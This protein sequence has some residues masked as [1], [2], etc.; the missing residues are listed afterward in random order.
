MD[1]SSSRSKPSIKRR[2]LE[3]EGQPSSQTLDAPQVPEDYDLNVMS[4]V[5][6][7]RE[8]PSN[9]QTPDLALDS[10]AILLAKQAFTSAFS[11]NP[12]IPQSM[13]VPSLVDPKDINAA[14]V[15]AVLS[16]QRLQDVLDKALDSLVRLYAGSLDSLDP[17]L[18]LGN[19]EASLAY[20]Q[21]SIG[22]VSR[23]AATDTIEKAKKSMATLEK[24]IDQLRKVYPDTTA[25]KI[26]NSKPLHLRNSSADFS[27]FR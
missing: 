5:M 24:T 14:S 16:A 8:L 11:A 4:T 18:L 9:P 10:V 19:A 17:Q 6:L 21:K 2:R 27:R 7:D 26:D 1:S 25:V 12:V 3:K 22:S 20:V 13:D 23:T 15:R